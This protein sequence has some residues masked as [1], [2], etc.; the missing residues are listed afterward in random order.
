[1]ANGSLPTQQEHHHRQSGLLKTIFSVSTG[2]PKTILSN[3]KPVETEK[4]HPD[5]AS[6]TC[7]K[8]AVGHK[9]DGKP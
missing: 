8:T 6:E 7:G 1:M 5:T 4:L 9:P 3:R 2:F